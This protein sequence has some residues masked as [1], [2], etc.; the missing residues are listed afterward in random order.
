MIFSQSYSDLYSNL[1]PK[2]YFLKNWLFRLKGLSHSL[3]EMVFFFEKKNHRTNMTVTSFKIIFEWQIWTFLIC[4]LDETFISGVYLLKKLHVK[5]F[6]FFWRY[7]P[8]AN[9]EKSPI[10]AKYLKIFEISSHHQLT[11]PLKTW[12]KILFIAKNN[13]LTCF[14]GIWK[15]ITCFE[16]FSRRE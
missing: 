8:Q 13:Y 3:P 7:T 5:G 4:T 10:W 6:A 16:W 14:R 15:L 1:S 12:D 2:K 9:L 11:K